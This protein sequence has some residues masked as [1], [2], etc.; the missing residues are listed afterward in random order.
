[1]RRS[2]ALSIL[3][4]AVLSALLVTILRAQL[5]QPATAPGSQPPPGN[6]GLVCS[7]A[8]KAKIDLI[9]PA[10]VGPLGLIQGQPFTIAYTVTNISPNQLVG[11]VGVAGNGQPLPDVRVEK[12]A[13]RVTDCLICQQAPASNR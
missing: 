12:R 4:T 3:R 13:L 8:P 10:H 2:R 5:P 1:M 6:C 11:Y 7:P 9:A